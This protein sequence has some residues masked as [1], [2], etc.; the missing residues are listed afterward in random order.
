MGKGVIPLSEH[1][2]AIYAGLDGQKEVQTD[3]KEDRWTDKSR[4]IDM[5]SQGGR[6]A[7]KSRKVSSW[8]DKS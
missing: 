8:A 2:I 3:N 1:R 7:G 6:K 4:K 5:T